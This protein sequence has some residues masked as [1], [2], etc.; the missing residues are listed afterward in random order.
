MIAMLKRIDNF[1]LNLN[2]AVVILYAFA[3]VATVIW[4][5]LLIFVACVMV[6]TGIAFYKGM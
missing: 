1:L 6:K 4:I 3:M 2:F 5:L